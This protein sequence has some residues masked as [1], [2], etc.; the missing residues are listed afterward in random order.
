MEL[1]RGGAAMK[2]ARDTPAKVANP[3][4][5]SSTVGKDTPAK[6]ANPANHSSTV[7]KDTPAKVANPANNGDRLEKLADLADLAALI[8]ENQPDGLADLAGLAARKSDILQTL[9]VEVFTLK[10]QIEPAPIPAS[11]ILYRLHAEVR[12]LEDVTQAQ[13]A[14]T[15]LLESTKGISRYPGSAGGMWG[16][17]IE[18]APLPQFRND[19]RAGLDPYKAEIRLIQIFDPVGNCYVFN[20]RK[21]PLALI[22]PLLESRETVA[23]NAIFE[24]R[25][26]RHAGIKPLRMHCTLLMAR[27]VSGQPLMSLAKAAAAYLPDLSDLPIDKALQ[28]S[29]WSADVLTQEQINYAA[30]DAVLARE[31][32]R[33][34]GE[35]IK[36]TGQSAAYKRMAAVIPVVA[37]QMLAGMGFDSSLHRQW[38]T[39][40][41]DEQLPLRDQLQRDIG[42]NPDSGTQLGAW[43]EKNLDAPSLAGW[44]RT[45]TGKLKTDEDAFEGIDLPESAGL[46]Q[47]KRLGKKISTFGTGYLEHIHPVTGRLHAEFLIAGTRGGRFS[48][49]KPN[50]QQAPTGDFRRLFIARP[51]YQLVV[52]DYSQIELRITAIIANDPIMLEAYR[53]GAD[54]HKK[55]AAA[56]AGIAEGDVTKAQRQ[57]AKACN[58]GLIYGMGSQTLAVYANTG[59]GVAMSLLEA[60]KARSKFFATYPG[61]RQ[62]QAATKSKGLRDSTVKT[63]GGLI[64]DL[65]KEPGGWQLTKALN[66]PV[67]G[68][69]AEMLL[70][71]LAQLPKALTGLDARLIHHVHDEIVL[72]V[73]DGDIDRAKIALVGAMEGGFKALFPDVNMT[74][75]VEAHSGTDWHSA[76]G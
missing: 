12:Y 34:L 10:A 2:F 70:A 22:K 11:A 75:L 41:Q 43:L 59:Y 65:A 27:V 74:G 50:L 55:T 5:H 35:L 67:Q 23:H 14:V 6:V 24:M 8:P 32:W 76:K 28:V 19:P 18:T 7:G 46:K 64:R 17:D 48:C 25:H 4:N 52:A 57:L 69:G 15:H 16:V 53:Q 9:G 56:I 38:L 61:I 68:T 40:W 21:I 72:E 39:Q 44:P 60:D 62:W 47:Y 3:A 20:L 54:L 36:Q 33:E 26:L 42:I 66:T 73:A 49:G 71:A 58:F 51:G 45:P 37:D 1:H 63:A 30:L 29:N 13:A 31:L